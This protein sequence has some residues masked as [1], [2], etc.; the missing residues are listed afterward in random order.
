M[1]RNPEQ[2]LAKPT[3]KTEQQQQQQQQKQS[4]DNQVNMG[5][6]RF[7]TGRQTLAQSSLP[8]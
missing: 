5:M 6:H 4:D 7:Y 3:N 8:Y 1:V 2:Q